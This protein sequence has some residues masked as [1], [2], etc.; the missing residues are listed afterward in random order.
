MSESIYWLTK[1][2]LRWWKHFEHE[3]KNYVHYDF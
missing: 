3:E 1:T 2:K